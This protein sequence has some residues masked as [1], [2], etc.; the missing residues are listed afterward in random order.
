[1]MGPSSISVRQRLPPN[2]GGGNFNSESADGNHR[3]AD[4]A[5]IDVAVNL[6]TPVQTFS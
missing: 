5:G 6:A 1:M 4:V 2:H 3:G